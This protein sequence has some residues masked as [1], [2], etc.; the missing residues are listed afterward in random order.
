MSAQFLKTR[1]KKCEY[2][3]K[4]MRNQSNGNKILYLRP[5][6]WKFDFLDI[7]NCF[8]LYI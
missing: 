4:D 6:M 2:K 1:H 7:S 8:K 5:M 3:L